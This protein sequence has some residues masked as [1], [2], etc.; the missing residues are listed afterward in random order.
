MNP[1]PVLRRLY[2][3]HR[4]LRMHRPD[5]DAVARARAGLLRDL[6]AF[7]AE[8]GTFLVQVL[9]GELFVNRQLVRPDDTTRPLFSELTHVL[10]NLGVEALAFLPGVSDHAIDGLAHQI[11]RGGLEPCKVGHIRVAPTSARRGLRALLS[12]EEHARQVYSALVRATLPLGEGEAVPLRELS[13]AL[14]LTADAVEDHPGAFRGLRVNGDVSPRVTVACS[15]AVHALQLGAALQ[16]APSDRLVVGLAAVLGSLMPANADASWLLRYGGLGS[17][18][19]RV[20]LT[21]HEAREASCPEEAG[22]LAQILALASGRD[23]VV[24]PRLS[25]CW[26]PK[27]RM[28][29]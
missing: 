1:S 28:V 16:I 27:G 4:I 22:V 26:A 11:A 15:R 14:L 21:V 23:A 6:E 2:G 17:L 19:P 25:E 5:N 13:R 8:H 12:D 10:S 20:V 24:D 18:A 29:A 7:H 3:L 9:T